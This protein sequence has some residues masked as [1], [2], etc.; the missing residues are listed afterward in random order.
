MKPTSYIFLALAAVLLFGGIIT[1]TVAESM[2]KA[3]GTEI[4]EQKKNKD[5]DMVYK[6]EL[7]DEK[8]SKLELEFE[9]V[10]I[11][12][13]GSSD[14]SYVEL[15]NFDPFQ[16]STTLSGSTV[17]VDGTVSGLS[18][19]IDLSGGGIKFKGLRYLFFDKP[20]ASRPRS[21]NVYIT[22]ASQI[23]TLNLNI[24]KGSVT[25]KNINNSIDYN[26]S[27][28]SGKVYLDNIVTESVIN[29]KITNGDVDIINSEFVSLFGDM[30][31]GKIS[32]DMSTVSPEFISY[33]VQT[34]NS[35]IYYN[36]I[37]DDDGQIKIATSPDLQKVSIKIDGDGTEIL[38]ADTSKK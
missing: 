38:L 34:E 3:N 2:A 37:L 19:L 5:G 31:G 17:S 13:I 27:S 28:Q 15:K 29:L 12:I 21:V 25:L 14:K 26:I 8:L 20:S 24:K 9:N 18:S 36:T 35:N 6:Y 4:F 32:V 10:E 11:N 22:D 30:T 16:Y 1:C 33:D 23:K 7:T